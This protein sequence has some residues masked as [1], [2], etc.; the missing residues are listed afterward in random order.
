[1]MAFSSTYETNRMFS[2]TTMPVTNLPQ[3]PSLPPRLCYFISRSNGTCVPLIPADELPYSF[4][5]QDVPRVMSIADTCG[6][7]HVGALPYTGQYFR[8]EKSTMQRPSSEPNACDGFHTRSQSATSMKQFLAPDAMVRAGLLGQAPA[9]HMPTSHPAMASRPASAALSA[10]NWR[11]PASD[12]IDST[13]AA[14]DAIVAANPETSARATPTSRTSTPPSGSAPDQERKIYCTHWIR[15]GECDYTQQGCLY[16]HEMP[17]RATLEKIGFRTVPRWYLEK[18]AP[19]LQ[20][21]SSL[22]T[23]GAPVKATEWLKRRSS[24]CSDADD[25]SEASESE[26]DSSES[27]S[28]DTKNKLLGIAE[29]DTLPKEVNGIMAKAEHEPAPP[30]TPRL[31]DNIRKLSL[32]DDLIDFAPLIPTPSP[33]DCSTLAVSPAGSTGS[34]LQRSSSESPRKE[35]LPSS[36]P[37]KT[38]KVFVPANESPEYHIA[39][40]RD[41]ARSA[42]TKPQHQPSAERQPNGTGSGTSNATTVG[43]LASSQPKQVQILQRPALSGLMA[44]RHAPRTTEPPASPAPA[45]S[46]RPKLIMRPRP[47]NTDSHNADLK[48]S[49]TGKRKTEAHVD[50]R[51]GPK[52]VCRERRPA[53]SAPVKARESGKA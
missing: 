41:R 50:C 34:S 29:K 4:R 28:K 17:N 2:A 21:M 27:D 25:E 18:T 7:Q 14:I 22:P 47:A 11:R 44:S 16:K 49:S 5:L 38:R 30:S 3:Q 46:S 23:V 45:S 40:S 33:S 19:R 6:M 12:T 9:P 43:S 48:V 53:G 37:R 26:E 32:N 36:S 35:H 1:M 24:S 10:S 39:Q 20:G 52:S 8:P 42:E 15:H 13:Q 51:S 31:F